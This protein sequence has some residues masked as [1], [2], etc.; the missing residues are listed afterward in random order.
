MHSNRCIVNIG[1]SEQVLQLLFELKVEHSTTIGEGVCE[2][3]SVL[4]TNLWCSEETHCVKRAKKKFW[5]QA[6]VSF[7]LVCIITIVQTPRKDL[8][9]LTNS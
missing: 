7:C 4:T 6:F 1:I 3:V 9:C 5:L 2:C 8:K